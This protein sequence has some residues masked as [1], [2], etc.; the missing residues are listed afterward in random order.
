MLRILTLLLAAFCA[1]PAGSAAIIT[2]ADLP[3]TGGTLEITEDSTLNIALGEHATLNGTIRLV[4]LSRFDIV[5]LGVLD[6]GAGVF[7]VFGG[8]LQLA[9]HGQITGN[10]LWFVDQYDG[11]SVLNYGTVTLNSLFLTANGNYGNITLDT[12]G[13]VLLNSLALDANYGGQ[14]TVNIL[15]GG[16]IQTR[17]LS[18]DASGYSHGQASA[19]YVNGGIQVVPEPATPALVGIGLALA[20]PLLARLSRKRPQPC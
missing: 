10:S 14:I 16:A 20:I 11:T 17:F 6:I 2:I 12:T 3:T 4:G 5:N 7:Q 1:V 9:S 13:T 15:S 18:Q 8:V 19:I